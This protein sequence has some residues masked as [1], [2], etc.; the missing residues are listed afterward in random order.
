[1]RGRWHYS[2]VSSGKP[3]RTPKHAQAYLGILCRVNKN[4]LRRVRR[5]ARSSSSQ[6][7]AELLCARI[8]V[9]ANRGVSEGKT[10][11]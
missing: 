6:G 2:M 5:A 1:M 8:M 11:L 9:V 4:R 3:G 7:S 10:D